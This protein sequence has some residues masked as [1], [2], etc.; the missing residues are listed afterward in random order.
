VIK[1]YGY[2]VPIIRDV[3]SVLKR[4]GRTLM[5]MATGT[6][7]TITSALVVQRLLR[8]HG[9]MLFL[10]HNND[11]LRQSMDSYHTVFNGTRTM[12]EFTGDKKES[13]Q[14]LF[15][16][17]QTMHGHRETFDPDFF[18]MIVV[19]EGHHSQADTYRPTIE[20][21]KPK[22]LL[23][24]TATP[25][26]E[27]GRDIRDIFGQPS[28]ELKLEEAIA[29]H[30]LSPVTYKLM[31]VGTASREAL[32]RLAKRV[33]DGDRI[34]L[35]D[36]NDNVF[37][38]NLDEDVAEEI[39]RH[40]G[41]GIIFCTSIQ[42][43]EL[44]ATRLKKAKPYHS[45][46]SHVD[47]RREL[48]AFREKRLRYLLTVDKFNEGIDIPHAEVVVFL[49][50]TESLTIF[51]QQLGRGLRKM[52]DKERVTA[53]DFVG[54]ADRIKMVSD[55]VGTI[56]D[57]EGPRDKDYSA[58][59]TSGIDFNLDAESRDVLD[60]LG[61][62]NV[63]FYSFEEARLVVRRAGVRNS[64][65]YST[66][67]GRDPRL[68]T[69]PDE[70]YASDW[71]NWPHFLTGEKAVEFYSFAEAMIAVRRMGLNSSN[72]R[73]RYKED[74]RLPSHPQVTYA[75]EWKGWKHF[76]TGVE[77]VEFYPFAEAMKVV[78]RMGIESQLD[79]RRRYKEDPRLPSAP[80]EIY[81]SEWKGWKHFLTGVEPVEF[82]PFAEA[83]KV[84]R[85][86]GIKTVTE[87][88]RRYKEDPRLHSDPGKFYIEWKGWKHFTG[89]EP[90]EFYPFV[91]AMRA[92]KLLHI[93]SGSEYKSRYKE[94]PRLHSNPD[95]FYASEWKGWAH[96]L[97]KIK[98]PKKS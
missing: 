8:A 96:F 16:S 17:F 97:G 11:I 66:L 45:E 4:D 2:Q 90:V 62:I 73:R 34:T 85:Q 64:R 40:K 31:T 7:K 93:K 57:I 35:R 76:L 27:D 70:T 60:I 1:P 59:D 78:Y 63:E 38:E 50:S 72:Y 83:M 53:L 54:N 56:R 89:V 14:F 65:E 36:L 20:Y 52:K 95:K 33:K 15:G 87:Y 21:F 49:R 55:F 92:V 61:R 37:V 22:Y 9:R 42:Q 69:R 44:M 32:K 28:V 12:G 23:A 68:P 58:F 30:Y 48:K 26:R 19:D 43:A 24:M 77:P 47:C 91:E 39:M 81:A 3:V 18:D 25:D 71:V 41:Q 6:G 86:K 75:S 51:L 82:Y 80:Y 29:R 94:D 67:V 5:V 46:M 79:Y 88:K 10:C 98:K 74:P 13:A 84:V